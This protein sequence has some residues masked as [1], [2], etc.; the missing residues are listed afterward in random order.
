MREVRQRQ[1]RGQ[2]R[3]LES[4]GEWFATRQLGDGCVRPPSTPVLCDRKRIARLSIEGPWMQS[5]WSNLPCSRFDGPVKRARS[6]Q[7]VGATQVAAP[8]AV[9]CVPAAAKPYRLESCHSMQTCPAASRSING[10]DPKIARK[11]L[12]W[13]KITCILIFY[14]LDNAETGQPPSRRIRSEFSTITIFTTNFS[15]DAYNAPNRCRTFANICR[16]SLGWMTSAWRS[17]R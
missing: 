13:N 3:H 2:R 10:S 12:A 15:T 16:I 4:R 11:V 8:A 17:A 1:C 9:R 7:Q 5:S 14:A 6:E